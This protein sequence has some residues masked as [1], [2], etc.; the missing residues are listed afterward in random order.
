M[1]LSGAAGLNAYI[2]LL[3][4]AIMQNRHV[5]S[6]TKPYD[7]M[8][9]WWVIAILVVL[10][11]IEIVVDK[12]PGADHLNDVVQTM[13]RPT[14]GAI[15]FA[16]QHDT[17]KFM[18]PWL[19]A[20]LGIVLSGGIHGGK[21]LARPVVNVSTAGMGAPIV[22]VVEDMVSTVLSLLAILLPILAVVMM[23]IFGWLL[24]KLFRKFFSR[25]RRR[26][27]EAI[28]VTAVPVSESP[29]ERPQMFGGG[30]DQREWGG[31]V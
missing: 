11:G 5:I 3:T 12:V 28:V 21:S 30:D 19:L 4:V 16:S 9:E 27:R 26:E 20:A 7:T 10:L 8:G 31:G 29:L 1:G 23:G 18:P 24:W 22:S 25:G 13:I 17:I 2:P 15:L 6:L 14:A